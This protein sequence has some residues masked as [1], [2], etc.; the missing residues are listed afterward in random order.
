MAVRLLEVLF[1]ALP[2]KGWFY[3]AFPIRQSSVEAESANTHQGYS[4]E[5]GQAALAF[6]NSKLSASSS[7]GGP[8]TSTS[9]TGGS[10][11]PPTSETVPHWGQCG[12]QGYTGS[13]S[14]AAPYT[15]T[16]SSA[17]YSQCL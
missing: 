9:P 14:C 16:Y 10:T 11:P 7:P 6:A 13:T 4:T 2:A 8:T 17:Y 5:Y 15:C 12:G 1:D 3:D